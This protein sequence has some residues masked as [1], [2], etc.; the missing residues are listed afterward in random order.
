MDRAAEAALEHGCSVLRMFVSVHLKGMPE[1]E[2]N[3]IGAAG[4]SEMSAHTVVRQRQLL[5]FLLDNTKSVA[6]ALGYDVALVPAGSE[7]RIRRS[8]GQT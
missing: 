6:K 1:G 8:E 7:V 2:M 3:A 4:G 5:E